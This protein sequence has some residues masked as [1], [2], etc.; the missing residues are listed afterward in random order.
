MH[1]GGEPRDGTEP[2]AFANERTFVARSRTAPALAVAR[3]AIAPRP[4]PFPGVPWGCHLL[5]VPLIVAGA[6][7]AVIGYLEW[8]RNPAGTSPLPGYCPAHSCRGSTRAPSP[9][10]R[11]PRLVLLSAAL[12]LYTQWG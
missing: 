11:S 10:W 7:L 1:G 9:R 5:G 8:G 6:V 12:L 3:L 2:D 4:P